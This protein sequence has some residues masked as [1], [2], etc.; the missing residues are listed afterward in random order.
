M[1]WTDLDTPAVLVDLDVMGRNLTRLADY[2]QQKD[3]KLRPHVKTH[4]IPGLARAQIANGATGLTVAK[5]GEAEVMAEAGVKDILVAYP[6]VGPQK[7]ERLARL[8]ERVQVSVALDSEDAAQVLAR[9]AQAARVTFRILVELD[10]GFRRCGIADEREALDLAQRVAGLPGLEFNGLMFYPG[11]LLVEPPQQLEM[12]KAVNHQ[13]DKTLDVF[14]RA[15]LPIPVVSGGSTP[16]A[17]ISHLFHGVNEIRPGMYLF[18]DRNMLGAQVTTIEHCALFVLVT[19]VSIAVQGQAIV[20]GGTKTFSSDRFLSGDRSG[21][22]L[23]RE[24]S[25]AQL[26]TMSEEHGQL[27]LSNSV[28]KYRIGEKLTVIPNHVCTTINMHDVI[29]GVR[30]DRVE[31]QWIVAARGKVT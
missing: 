6:I 27:D 25:T 22:G 4:K 23:V 5:V 10:V 11:H 30:S 26:S 28:R 16:T 31:E 17:Y 7:A 14:E 1:Y 12:L 21:F 24:D 13:L 2:C 20:D 9:A 3:L 29:Y 8:A 19:V 18:N 15:S